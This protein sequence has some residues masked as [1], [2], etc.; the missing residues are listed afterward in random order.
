MN[1]KDEYLKWDPSNFGNVSVL[2]IP[3]TE[4]WRPDL[5]IYTAVPVESVFLEPL[6]Q[7]LI[8]YD[9]TVLWVPPVTIK[10][11]CPLFNR[12]PKNAIKCNIRLGS[13]TYSE[14]EMDVYL[15]SPE[16]DVSNFIDSNVEWKLMEARAS[17]EP[18]HYPCCKEAYPLLHF[19]VTLKRRKPFSENELLMP[20]NSDL[21]PVELGKTKKIIET[22]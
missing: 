2:R 22:D 11:R 14:N 3:S 8:Y 10:S 4:I 18:K 1:W 20:E 16:V 6:T 15:S 5:S 9:G 21:N 19:N 17:R 12:A 7:A 13:W